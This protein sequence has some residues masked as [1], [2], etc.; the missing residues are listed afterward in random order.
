MATKRRETADFEVASPA[1]AGKSPLAS[2]GRRTARAYLRVETVSSMM[3]IAQDCKSA[4]SESNS[5]LGKLIS[6]PARSRTRGRVS[7]TLPP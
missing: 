3:F 2:P 1:R 7:F 6:L 4:G 5:Q